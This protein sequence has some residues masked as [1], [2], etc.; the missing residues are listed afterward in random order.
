MTRLIHLAEL[1]GRVEI[2]ALKYLLSLLPNLEIALVG[3][4]GQMPLVNDYQTFQPNLFI[5]GSEIQGMVTYTPVGV[6]AGE[7]AVGGKMGGKLKC[8]WSRG[9][10]V[11]Q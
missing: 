3:E 9:A 1:S 5:S 8:G 2:M 11:V 4:S 10:W 7:M 6:G